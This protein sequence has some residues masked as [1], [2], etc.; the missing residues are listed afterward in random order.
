VDDFNKDLIPA[1]T[2]EAVEAAKQKIISGQIKVTN[3][4]EK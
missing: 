3:A 2:L 4:M 1:S